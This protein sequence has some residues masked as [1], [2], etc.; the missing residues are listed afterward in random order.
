[1]AIL[2][3]N[4]KS[5]CPKF[6]WFITILLSI[7]IVAT[8]A[9]STAGFIITI[10]EDLDN[11]IVIIVYV[12]LCIIFDLLYIFIFFSLRNPRLV[13]YENKVEYTNIF[14]AKRVLYGELTKITFKGYFG[15]G[16]RITNIKTG[17]AIKTHAMTKSVYLIKE[18]EIANIEIE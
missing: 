3:F 1:M 12:L 6:Y 5:S 17:E 11:Y 2:D 13:I 16:I 14:K 7:L 18:C 8:T 4:V 9:G 10:L 15:Y